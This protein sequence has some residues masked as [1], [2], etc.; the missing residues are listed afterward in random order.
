MAMVGIDASKFPFTIFGTP[1]SAGGIGSSPA[2][3]KQA[4]AEVI[5]AIAQAVAE[6]MVI[7]FQNTTQL[8]GQNMAY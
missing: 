6:K 4:A 8:D 7:N 1:S 3:A 5:E 2:D